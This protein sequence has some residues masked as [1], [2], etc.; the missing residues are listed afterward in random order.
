MRT[1][2]I[3]RRIAAICTTA[4]AITLTAAPA[5]AQFGRGFNFDGGLETTLDTD[6]LEQ[7][8]Q[9]LGLDQ[10]QEFVARDFLAGFQT[11]HSRLLEERETLMAAARET[12]RENRDPSIWREVGEASQDIAQDAKKL[13]EQ[14]FD[15]LKLVLNDEQLD[16]WPTVMRDHRRTSTIERGF[17]SGES[18]DLVQ[19]VNTVL[20][21][22][23]PSALNEML[24]SYANDLDRVLTARN[25]TYESGMSQA[26]TLFQQ[27]DFETIQELF[28]KARKAGE[29]VR[30]VNQR[31]ARQIQP[32]VPE[33]AQGDFEREVKERTF[34][35]IYA[36]S[37][38][39]RVF[40][41]V[42]QIDSLT[43]EQSDQIASIRSTYDRQ[44]ESINTRWEKAIV[45]TEE[46]TDVMSMMRGRFR[47]AE[48]ATRTSTPPSRRDE[49]DGSSTKKSPSRSAPS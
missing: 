40:S 10:D 28:E 22:D 48:G 4:L 17:L 25:E 27:R 2:A 16:R 45:E 12:F 32:L 9:T 5:S 30:D 37:Y 11:E 42:D 44:A 18:V 39:G 35:S 21:D 41:S 1:P 34:P 33:S 23:R 14:F 31:Y 8:V 19:V 24:D 3:S 36:R 46:N 6:Q 26:R 7:I 38:A 13:E 29:K 43:Q 20:T 49:S 15:D 47:A